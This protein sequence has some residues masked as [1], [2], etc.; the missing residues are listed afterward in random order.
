MRVIRRTSPIMVPEP[1]MLLIQFGIQPQR[2]ARES[3][4]EDVSKSVH[5]VKEVT[6]SAVVNELAQ[7]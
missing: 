4:Y 5:Q 1:Q 6:Y 2:V 3:V 7:L